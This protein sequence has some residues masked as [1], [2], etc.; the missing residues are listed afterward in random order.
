MTITR[1]RKLILT[2]VF[3]Q[4]AFVFPVVLNIP[5]AR[6]V[7]VFLCLIFMPG[8]MIVKALRLGGLHWVE[9]VCFTV[10]F[11]LAFLMIVGL[12]I[13]Q[14]GPLISFLRPLSELPL[15]LVLDG[16]LV[17][18]FVLGYIT[19]TEFKFN[20]PRDLKL[21]RSIVSAIPF[22]LLPILSIVGAFWVNAYGD[23]RILL[24][25]IMAIAGLFVLGVLSGKMLPEKLYPI[26][27]ASI[28]IA[29][30]FH[31][32][33]VSHYITGVDIQLEYYSFRLTQDAALWN[34]VTR[35]W[36]DYTYNRFNS[37]IGITILPTIF[38][39]LLN[40][41]AT[42]T[43]KIVYPLI[44]SLVPLCLYQIWQTFIGKKRA[45]VTAFFFMAQLTFYTEMLA[46]AREMIAEL[47][48]VLLLFVLLNNKM[49]PFNR[50]LCFIVFAAGLVVSHYSM[51]IIFLV[52]ISLVLISLFLM[53]KP[54]TIITLGMVVFFFGIMFSWYIF[55]SS[56]GAFTSFLAFGENVYGDLS[57]FLSMS[58]RGAGVM[59]GLGLESAPTIWNTASRIFA[60]ATQFLIVVG[61]IMLV[62]G[63]NKRTPTH[64]SF[65]SEYMIFS[66]MNMVLLA[67]LIIVPGLAETMRMER[68]YHILSFILAP[69]CVLGAEKLVSLV[70][71]SKTELKTLILLLIVL[72]PYFFFQTNFIYEVVGSRS[73]S[74]PLSGY[75]M[76]RF[77]LYFSYG[78][79]DERSVFGAQWMSEH[80]SAR[81]MSM[82]K[83]VCADLISTWGVLTSYGMLYRGKVDVLS[84]Q[85][86]VGGGGTVYLNPFN[87]IDGSFLD[88]S[89][90]PTRIG[91]TTEISLVIGN[92]DKLYSNGASEVYQN[93]QT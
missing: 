59:R 39:D 33:L 89:T 16:A 85:T 1:L 20:V 86:I 12:F 46:L 83:P 82:D 90:Y 48:F 8:F 56:S 44:F 87:V 29:L 77:R 78:Y 10:G 13:N 75:R 91:N 28:A 49:K 66:S 43:L 71:K 60:Y 24:F 61:F 41:D 40:I 25:L 45:L 38:S 93:G 67:S 14:T 74:V 27:L 54:S 34:S 73:E 5:L 50:K 79:I 26:A 4:F 17:S 6:Q 84:N 55:T 58:S 92:L 32:S 51:S 18:M 35:Y 19:K 53:K 47:F 30:L 88:S 80:L 9:M 2:I 52:S 68:F 62:I 63:R 11:S 81:A 3:L 72:I 57:G 65:S 31:F 36:W 76:D 69:F 22:V 42:W 15:I 21:D 7:I 23:N 37:M 64:V 70:T